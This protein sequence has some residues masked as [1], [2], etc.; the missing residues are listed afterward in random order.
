MYASGTIAKT[1]VPLSL[2]GLMLV[3]TSG[4]DGDLRARGDRTHSSLPASNSQTSS[5]CSFLTSTAIGWIML[6]NEKGS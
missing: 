5:C 6:A 3:L 1:Y 4:G 2:N